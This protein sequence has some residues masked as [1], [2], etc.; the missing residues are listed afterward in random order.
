[1]AY[2]GSVGP[3]GARNKMRPVP[4]D[5]GWP[6]PPLFRPLASHVPESS[7]VIPFPAVRR[8]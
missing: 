5:R 6:P 2:R 8:A 3:V 4:R 7:K 1:M